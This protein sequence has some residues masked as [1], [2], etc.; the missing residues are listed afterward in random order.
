MLTKLFIDSD[1][2]IE[3]NSRTEAIVYA[4]KHAVPKYILMT[5]YPMSQTIC[6]FNPF[7]TENFTEYF[8]TES[9]ALKYIGSFFVKRAKVLQ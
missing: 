5:V 3:F 6:I 2:Y 9:E 8:D 1:T 4:E 7:L